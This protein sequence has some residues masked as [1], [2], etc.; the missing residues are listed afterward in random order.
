MCRF[1]PD[2]LQMDIDSHLN[3]PRKTFQV[4][5]A[6]NYTTTNPA[7]ASRKSTRRGKG[8]K[9]MTLGVSATTLAMFMKSLIKCYNPPGK[10]FEGAPKLFCEDKAVL[11]RVASDAYVR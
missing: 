2:S 5:L 3:G 1:E 11:C 6:G 9:P 8:S 4:L 10:I 7:R